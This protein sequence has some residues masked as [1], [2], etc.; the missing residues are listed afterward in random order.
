MQNIKHKH[1]TIQLTIP[2]SSHN[3]F[4]TFRFP[5]ARLSVIKNSHILS[6]MEDKLS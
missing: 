3:F 5:L 6:K 4:E 2:D 1:F